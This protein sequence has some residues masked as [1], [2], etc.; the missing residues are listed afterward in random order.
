MAKFYGEVGYGES[1]ETDPGVWE[2]RIIE[3]PYY[4]DVVRAS[5]LLKEGEN[6]TGELSISN[7]ISIVADA[8]ANEHFFAIRYVK[9]AG[10]LWTV[11]N[12][13]VKSPR[14]ILQVGGVYNGPRPEAGGTPE[15]S[16]EST[17]Y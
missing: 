7:S 16:R 4:G 1:V 6:L 11:S 10:A 2:D 5:R 9:W 14:L 15:S 12:V 13:E 8:Y 17:G 3:R